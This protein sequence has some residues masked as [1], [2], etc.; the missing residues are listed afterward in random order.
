MPRHF[1]LIELLVVI[2][3][4]AIL[5]GMLLPALNAAREKAKEISCLSNNKQLGLAFSMYISDNADYYPYGF[6]SKNW[7]GVSSGAFYP[8][9]VSYQA[10]YIHPKILYCNSLTVGNKDAIDKIL[11]VGPGS[12]YDQYSSYGYNY[13]S[14]GGNADGDPINATNTKTQKAGLIK[15]PSR[16][17]SHLEN[18]TYSFAAGTKPEKFYGLAYVASSYALAGRDLTGTP[19]GPHRNNGISLFCDGRAESLKVGKA[20]GLSQA[21]YTRWRNMAGRN[22]FSAN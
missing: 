4:I 10:R 15:H 16:T 1:T 8:A 2:A 11:T 6:V 7:L 22:Y 12:G 20:L 17:F 9:F 18:V 14:L 13:H 21:F 19:W 5:A 3:I